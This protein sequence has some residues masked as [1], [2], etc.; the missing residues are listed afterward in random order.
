MRRIIHLQKL[1][2]SGLHQIVS[3]DGRIPVLPQQLHQ[4]PPE[5]R[6]RALLVDKLLAIPDAERGGRGLVSLTIAGTGEGRDVEVEV[7]SGIDEDL[8]DA[9]KDGATELNGVG[10]GVPSIDGGG[11]AA[12]VGVSLEDSDVERDVGGGGELL[13]VVG[14]RRATSSCPCRMR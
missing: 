6:L 13:E 5:A 7:R 1:P 12:D 9:D 14:C 11:A 8:I 3:L 2:H 4:V 10:W